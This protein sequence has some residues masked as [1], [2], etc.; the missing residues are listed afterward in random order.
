MVIIFLATGHFHE[1]D[2]ERY[3]DDTDGTDSHG[4]F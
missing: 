1:E 4:Y 2:Q 3:A